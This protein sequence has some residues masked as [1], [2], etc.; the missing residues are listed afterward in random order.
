MF[1]LGSVLI[2]KLMGRLWKTC[3]SAIIDL[4]STYMVDRSDKM[5]CFPVAH[6][7]NNE[8][9]ILLPKKQLFKARITT[10]ISV[11]Y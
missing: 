10:G 1:I 6:A 2:H 4:N 3:I 9:Q 7:L 8:M 5:V 11:L